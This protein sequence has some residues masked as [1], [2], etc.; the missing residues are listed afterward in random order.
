MPASEITLFG[1]M[2]VFCLQ[3]KEAT[4]LAGE[5]SDYLTHGI[6]LNAGDTVFDVGANIGIFSLWLCRTYPGQLRI[7]AF[8]P[9]PAIADVLAR[10]ARRFAPDHLHVLPFGLSDATREV[11]FTYYPKAT[12]WST[13]YPDIA[14]RERGQTK[15]ATLRNLQ[16]APRWVRAVPVQFWSVLI[17]WVLKRVMRKTQ[18]VRCHLQTLSAVIREQQIAR[19]DLLKVDV[20]HGE[21][22]VLRGIDDT[23]W[24][25][26]RQVV[27]EVHDIDGKRQQITDLLARQGFSRVIAHQQDIL[28]DTNIYLL[29]AIR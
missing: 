5:V 23:H 9:I 26:I 18:T 16:K 27:L 22:E 2:P 24:P 12:V 15:Q 28:T 20:E 10:N 29:Y 1:D 11:A 3:P 25:L 13:A 19:I 7:F 6:T 4:Y 14:Y 21:L 17:D 8:E